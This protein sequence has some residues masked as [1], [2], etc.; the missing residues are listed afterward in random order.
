MACEQWV[1]RGGS[2]TDSMALVLAF[3]G[4]Y[5]ADAVYNEVRCI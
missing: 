2:L 5:I 3:Q 4:I 1:R